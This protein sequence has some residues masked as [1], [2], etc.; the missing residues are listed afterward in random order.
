MLA[1]GAG[2]PME[3]P[4]LSDVR[5]HSPCSTSMLAIAAAFCSAA[6]ASLT[7]IQLEAPL[8]WL[9]TYPWSC[10]EKELQRVWQPFRQQIGRCTHLAALAVHGLLGVAPMPRDRVSRVLA[11]ALR[12]SS[13]LRSLTLSAVAPPSEPWGVDVELSD[14]I[15]G[16]A[17]ATLMCLWSV[18]VSDLHCLISFDSVQPLLEACM[19]VPHVSDLALFVPGVTGAAAGCSCAWEARSQERELKQGPSRCWW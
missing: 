13:R 11:D 18:V 7:S 3:L 14:G 5:L 15:I 1:G 10:G 2:C 16:S 19:H 17:L 4:L 8:H 9:Y 6:S 12:P